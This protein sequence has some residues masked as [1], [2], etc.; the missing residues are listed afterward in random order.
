M[1]RS[2]PTIAMIALTGVLLAAVIVAPRAGA[3]AGAPDLPTS[4]PP[5]TPARFLVTFN[6][7]Q[8]HPAPASAA[9][10]NLLPQAAASGARYASGEILVKF[11]ETLPANDQISLL[12]EHGLSVIAELLLPG[13]LR[14]KTPDGQELAWAQTL[15][16]DGR[17]AYAEPN[18]QRSIRPPV[19]S[20][21]VS[22]ATDGGAA[23]AHTPDDPYFA[24]LQWNLRTIKAP[25]A[26][27]TTTGSSAVIL[28]VIDTGL[29]LGHP[30][31]SCR[32]K[33]VSGYDF[34]NNDS[35]AQDDHGHGTHVAGIAAACT[36]NGGGV[37]GVNWN[38]AIMPVKVLGANG[39][40][41]AS[42]VADG[43]VWAVNH[44]ARVINLS[45][46]SSD[47][48]QA[49]RDAVTYAYNHDVLVIAAAGNEYAEGNPISYPAAYAHVLA[50]AATGDRDERAAYS[51]TGAY[52]DVAAP[53]G[54]PTSASDLTP[55]HW[56]M[57]TYWRGG[58]ASYVQ[59][60]GTSQAAPHVAGLAALIR[61]LNAS[62]PAGQVQTI[63]QNTADDIGTIG[64]DDAFG[65]GRIN[66]QAAVLAAGGTPP[67]ATRTQTP[68]I[69]PTPRTAT[70]SPSPTLIAAPSPTRTPT[71][72]PTSEWVTI[73]EETFE[74]DFP[75]D[76]QVFDQATNNGEHYWAK[77][78]CRPFAGGFSGWAVGGGDDGSALA[79]GSDYPD[80]AA[81]HMIY[82]PFS[83]ADASDA[84]LTLK[85]WMNNEPGVDKFCTTASLD[86]AIFLGNCTFT[87]TDGWE[88]S[89]LDLTNISGLGT[90]IGHDQ[91]WVGLHFIS[92]ANVVRA[93]G[94]YVDN[95]VL[96]KLISAGNV[97]TPTATA[98]SVASAT[99]TSTR[100]PSSTAGAS[101]TATRTTTRTRTPTQPSSPPTRT[102]TQPSSP[103]T[104]TPTQPSS[105]PP[106]VVAT[107]TPPPDCIF[108]DFNCDCVVD[109]N[110]LQLAAAHWR[111]TP[112]SPNWD[113]RFDVDNDGDVDVID[114]QRVAGALGA[115]CP[116]AG[117]APRE[118][119]ARS[120]LAQADG[121]VSIEPPSLDVALART[122]AT[123]AV[124]GH[125]MQGIGALQIELHFDP[126]VISVTNVTLG[127]F[128][129]SSGRTFVTLP[130]A[131][132]ADSIV[133]AAFSYGHQTGA[134][135]SG[136]LANVTIQPVA[137][138]ESALALVDVR[139]AGVSGDALIVTTQD[140]WL[141]VHPD[142]RIVLP[143]ILA[144]FQP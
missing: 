41:S 142:N 100:T 28:A 2:R 129:A 89:T 7:T 19:L 63:I 67:T 17:V 15:S 71:S 82:G 16:K 99:H 62:L 52:V 56:I 106:T 80:M 138:G 81:S 132:G 121:R 117:A 84:R 111:T 115:R 55:G 127:S 108:A 97:R 45:L 35:S 109:M 95:I 49:E 131:V 76:W 91:V 14:V 64:R 5:A 116:A 10:A 74:G 134:A 104:R 83:L 113:A 65:H 144:S 39:S 57:S 8:R 128:P 46:G 47:A 98:T 75:G 4:S 120:S 18:Y 79:C 3:V 21:A 66:A 87:P 140:G 73:V 78:S 53:G 124:S 133:F 33:I 85:L 90:L 58:G 25:Q 105:P 59:M 44:G 136:T 110:D 40:G 93:E 143:I 48:S 60:V 114:L 77:R 112:A 34:Y 42:A 1:L 54:N 38:V 68:G 123:V 107:A 135:G 50:V 24:S 51:N 26:W 119:A 37:A 102:P 103:P 29:D 36:N 27:D 9:Q 6:L 32:G 122:A 139:I 130:L 13:V 22:T 88:D 125:D 31:L 30:D 126:Q 96:R 118:P 23:T 92:N 72:L 94:A 86:G 137:V 70:P 61:G 141:T 20:S 12:H 101:R 69:V 11:A 43:I